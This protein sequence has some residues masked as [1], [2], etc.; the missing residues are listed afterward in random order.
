[1]KTIPSNSKI[2]NVGKEHL[3]AVL[4]CGGVFLGGVQWETLAREWSLSLGPP[5]PHLEDYVSNFSTWVADNCEIFHIDQTAMMKWTICQEFSDMF[6]GTGNPVTSVLQ[7]RVGDPTKLSEPEFEKAL[8]A[9]IEDY[10]KNCFITTPYGDLTNDAVIKNLDDAKIDVYEDF[11]EHAQE[12]GKFEF[13]EKF[14]KFLLTF[15]GE[16]LIRFVNT[17]GVTCLNFVGF[18][19]KDIMGGRI[20]LRIRSFY[21]GKLRFSFESSGSADP[22]DYPMWF[23]LAQQD[24]MASFM[25][26]VDFEA[27]N[28]LR[29]IAL[30]I[31]MSKVKLED[32][33]VAE[34]MEEY[35]KR[36]YDFLGKQFAQPL[37][38]TMDTLGIWSLTRF[39][40]MLVRIQC[41]RSASLSS[42]ATVGGLIES[43]EITRDN[44]VRWHQKIS[45][46]SHSIE[47]AS[48]VFA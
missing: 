23:P 3:V 14:R 45:L 8:T 4:H 48:H 16:L 46:E 2:H 34:F 6:A 17:S 35:G 15:A 26:G 36:T 12:F 42:E 47:D 27:R 37:G 11:L 28:S 7:Q 18:G 41:L 22:K 33:Q 40:D 32:S 9:A 29:D 25:W 44:G 5:L 19:T 24:A 38:E 20:E 1:M 10:M 43:L 13:S 39:A 31:V 21:G 30:D